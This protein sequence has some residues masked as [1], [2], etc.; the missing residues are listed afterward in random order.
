MNILDFLQQDFHLTDSEMKSIQLVKES[1][2]DSFT[3]KND[4]IIKKP[5]KS[6]KK[7]PSFKKKLQVVL[8]Q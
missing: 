3:Y 5:V 6:T 1:T 7:K 8:H 2:E 4:Y